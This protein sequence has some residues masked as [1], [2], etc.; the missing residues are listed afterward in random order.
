MRLAPGNLDRWT[1]EAEAR[2]SLI[3]V[4]DKLSRSLWRGTP[5]TFAP[6]VAV[7]PL[8][9]PWGS[10][11]QSLP[12]RMV[13]DDVV[14]VT[15]PYAK[16]DSSTADRTADE[17]EKLTVHHEACPQHTDLQMCFVNARA[18]RLSP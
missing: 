6:E 3:V 2:L 9:A 13:G 14:K 8:A 16:S 15:R 10:T 4:L 11:R 5:Q 17:E 1:H 12:L 7:L 18:N